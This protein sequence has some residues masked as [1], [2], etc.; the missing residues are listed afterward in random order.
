MLSNKSKA[1]IKTIPTDTKSVISVFTNLGFKTKWF[2]AHNSI[3]NNG[4]IIFNIASEAL[5]YKFKNNII[6]SLKFGDRMYD[7]E[8]IP[9]LTKALQNNNQFITLHTYG[10][11]F[12]F[13]QRYPKEFALFKPECKNKG[14][15]KNIL[16]ECSKKSLINS[17]D[18]SIIY[19]DNFL[20]KI[21][22][23]IKDSNTILFFV[24]DHGVALGEKGSLYNGSS[25]LLKTKIHQVP[26]MIYMTDSVLKNSFYKKKFLAAKKK[27]NKIMSHDNIF[28][29][30]LGCIGINSDIIDQNL[31]ICQ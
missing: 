5:E 29:S 13:Y 20:S 25:D 14:K 17:Y 18:N 3:E 31:N 9:F 22:K 6:S 11:H 7:E 4:S 30:L 23:I 21:I 2:S 12:K 1:N 10:S 24:A 28:H 26:I 15:N 27:Q 19:T 16:N 8:L